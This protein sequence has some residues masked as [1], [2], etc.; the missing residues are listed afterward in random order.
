MVER[1]IEVGCEDAGARGR[2]SDLQVRR[3]LPAGLELP[4]P[5]LAGGDPD[6]CG[7]EGFEEAQADG[8]VRLLRAGRV[9]V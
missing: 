8:P 2:G 1:P 4:L 5:A 7:R 9:Q 3:G 6:L